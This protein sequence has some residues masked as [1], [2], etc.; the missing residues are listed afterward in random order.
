MHLPNVY[1]HMCITCVC[2]CAGQGSDRWGLY[3]REQAGAA[4]SKVLKAI[5]IAAPW[6]KTRFGR[7]SYLILVCL[8]IF[9][10]YSITVFTILISYNVFERPTAVHWMRAC[11]IRIFT[12][13]KDI[14]FTARWGKKKDERVFML[15]A[16]TETI[17]RGNYANWRNSQTEVITMEPVICFS[18]I[19]ELTKAISVSVFR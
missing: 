11:N 1:A 2:V 3:W 18:E 9:H 16:E 4:A 17:L 19:N 14:G 12:D 6:L 5:R 13:R 10:Q 8:L 15:Y 7:P